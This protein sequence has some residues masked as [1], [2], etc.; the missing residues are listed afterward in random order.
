MV[1]R[2]MNR[3]IHAMVPGVKNVAE[4]EEN[5]RLCDL[6]PIPPEHLEKLR[7]LDLKCF[8]E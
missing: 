6:P 7:E 5:S 1:F 2:L 4:T 3:D 8:R